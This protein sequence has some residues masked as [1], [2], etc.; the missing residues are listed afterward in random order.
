MT[1]KAPKKVKRGAT[2]IRITCSVRLTARTKVKLVRPGRVVARG[3]VSRSGRVVL[4]GRKP[5]P[6][7]YTL[8]AGALRI[9]VTV[10]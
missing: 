3:V 8:V 4:R 7:N 9:G 1:C 6:G 10:R 5:K 2:N